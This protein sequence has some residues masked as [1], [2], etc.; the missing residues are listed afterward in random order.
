MTSTRA[1]LTGARL[2]ADAS[3]LEVSVSC[4]G[5][6]IPGVSVAAASESA[7]VLE[8][9]WSACA[10]GA[11]MRGSVGVTGFEASPEVAL[12]K[13]HGARPAVR[14]APWR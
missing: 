10:A 12:G 1:V 7:V 3:L 11:E 5:K 9:D 13:L 8:G 4:D 6:T 2:P 14:C